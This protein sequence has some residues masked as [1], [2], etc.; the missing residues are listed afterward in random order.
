MFSPQ[1]QASRKSTS[2]ARTSAAAQPGQP[3]DYH[4]LFATEK[5]YLQLAQGFYKWSV[6]DINV[7][8][9][10]KYGKLPKPAA[11]L[12]SLVWTRKREG[13]GVAEL[14]YSIIV[15][16]FAMGLSK[17]SAIFHSGVNHHQE[18]YELKRTYYNLH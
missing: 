10:Q 15:L 12:K 3:Q 8:V 1:P 6:E 11:P 14:F 18:S 2:L 4:K 17:G 13:N 16:L 5:E 7:R 9:L